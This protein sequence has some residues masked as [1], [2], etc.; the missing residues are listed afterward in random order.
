MDYGFGRQEKL[1]AFRCKNGMGRNG[2]KKARE[3]PPCGVR[4]GGLWPSMAWGDDYDAIVDA[5]C[6]AWND[7]LAIPDRIASITKRKWATV[8]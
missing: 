2:R 1:F 3:P 7:L 4:G 8:S 6:T 5:C